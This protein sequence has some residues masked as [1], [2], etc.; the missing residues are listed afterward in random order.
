MT[1]QISLS[2]FRRGYQAF[3]THE[4]RDA[5]YKIAT[6][7]VS[8]FWGRPADMADGLGVLLLTWNQA[9]YRY[10]SFDFDRLE[11]VIQ[12]NLAIVQDYHNRDIVTLET[13]DEPL[14]KKLFGQLILS[15]AIL[16][17]GLR[18]SLMASRLIR[19]IPL[20][21]PSLSRNDTHLAI[22]SMLE[23]MPPAGAY[24]GSVPTFAQSP[25]VTTPFFLMAGCMMFATVSGLPTL[26]S[27][28]KLL[29]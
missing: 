24:K 6:F 3:Q 4:A 26:F 8:Q 15:P 21:T 27:K 28:S 9:F 25:F 17:R 14:I 20:K 19:R 23:I 11:H 29:V 18:I 2:E 22:S 10:G 12:A 7:V 1:I 16:R 5:M 13:P